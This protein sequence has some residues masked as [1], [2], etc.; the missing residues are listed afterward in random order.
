MKRKEREDEVDDNIIT[1]DEEEEYTEEELKTI[2][3]KDIC[4]HRSTNK[5]QHLT[6]NN[7][8]DNNNNDI[9]LKY[10][11]HRY[12]DDS[13]VGGVGGTVLPWFIIERILTLASYNA[14]I[15]TCVHND[16][17]RDVM[18]LL[19][20]KQYAL[21]TMNTKGLA[22]LQM[23]PIIEQS[24][25]RQDMCPIHQYNYD[26]GH[27][28]RPNLYL[29]NSNNNIIGR[30]LDD[31]GVH[32]EPTKDTYNHIQNKHC[33]IK[34]PTTLYLVRPFHDSFHKPFYV[35]NEA[36]K[37][38]RKVHIQGAVP[39][40]QQPLVKGI[41]TMLSDAMPKLRSIVQYERIDVALLR[42]IPNA[43]FTNLRSINFLNA[44][45]TEMAFNHIDKLLLQSN[46]QT[47][48]E[49]LPKLKHI[50]FVG[51]HWQ[52]PTAVLVPTSVDKLSFD[53]RP[54]NA[55]VLNNFPNVTIVRFKHIGYDPQSHYTVNGCYN[56][57]NFKQTNIK[58]IIIHSPFDILKGDVSRYK[59]IGYQF[60]DSTLI[61]NFKKFIFKKLENI[62]NNNNNIDNNNNNN[63]N[64]NNIDNI[65]HST[66]TTTNNL[67][68][69]NNNFEKRLPN[70]IMRNII[71]MVWNLRDRCTCIFEQSFMKRLEQPGLEFLKDKELIQ[72][73]YS[74]KNECAVHFSTT[75]RLFIPQH[76][77]IRESTRSK[78]Q[79]A[80]ISKDIFRFV[81]NHL[82]NNIILPNNNNNNY[83][84]QNIINNNN[85]LAH[86]NNLNCVF[87][88]I[89]SVVC[90]NANNN[91]FKFN[92]QDYQTIASIKYLKATEIPPLFPNLTKL[93]IRDC[94]IPY[95]ALIFPK[96]AEALKGKSITKLYFPSNCISAYSILSE[97]IKLSL[98]C[99]VTNLS[100]DVNLNE[101]P[102][103]VALVV[104]NISSTTIDQT[105]KLPPKI[106][107]ITTNQ[108]GII[109]INPTVPT[110]KILYNEMEYHQIQPMLNK[111]SSFSQISKV[112]IQ[113]KSYCDL[114][115]TPSESCFQLDGSLSKQIYSQ[116]DNNINK[117][118]QPPQQQQQ[119]QQQQQIPLPPT[120]KPT[121]KRNAKTKRQQP[122]QHQHLLPTIIQQQQPVQQ[123]HNNNN[124]NNSAFPN[125]PQQPSPIYSKNGSSKV[126]CRFVNLNFR[127]DSKVLNIP[128]PDQATLEMAKM[129]FYIKF[130][131]KNS[132]EYTESEYQHFKFYYNDQPIQSHSKFIYEFDLQDGHFIRAEWESKWKTVQ[133]QG[134]EM[135][136]LSMRIQ[137]D[138]LLEDIVK[139]Y[140]QG[141]PPP[142]EY[143]N[144]RVEYNGVRLDLTGDVGSSQIKKN[145]FLKI[146]SSSDIIHVHV[147]PSWNIGEKEIYALHKQ[148]TVLS[149]LVDS[150]LK[151]HQLHPRQINFTSASTGAV[152][153]PNKPSLD[154]G[155]EMDSVIH[156]NLILSRIDVTYQP[157][158]VPYLLSTNTCFESLI[159]RFCERLNINRSTV[160]FVYDN[161]K[162]VPEETPEHIK[163]GPQANIQV[164]SNG[165]T[166]QQ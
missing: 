118:N 73:Y 28:S 103:L 24:L 49:D 76:H 109:R 72:Q 68:T 131:L 3:R 99:I 152:I 132:P 114:Y 35:D 106:K 160:Q 140:F 138:T 22:Q 85:Y 71:S 123:V 100:Q 5:Q 25:C 147:I 87:K 107:K 50:Y 26:M 84:N 149:K 2:Y 101:F 42:A 86:R 124:N 135:E 70:Y 96:L 23:Q 10:Y 79:L 120:P 110:L 127:W 136:I 66:T 46:R 102:N 146:V 122:Q 150:F 44:T 161:K 77:T 105:L 36:L 63:N 15:C 60:I 139:A 144:L 57:V 78:L 113:I 119:Q 12:L 92:E 108:E 59:E 164:T 142:Y 48:Q 134:F 95:D 89:R 52:N 18:E 29:R 51:G 90:Y 16:A 151:K 6:T 47:K 166:V 61:N 116:Q 37:R 21:N 32:L 121:Q 115:N 129:M 158:T 117:L 40:K 58:K 80:L 104:M 112:I 55:K 62:N 130:D 8:N 154:Q 133:V 94:S 43:P 34:N 27:R 53:T 4:Y 20:S 126:I 81:S 143:K 159:Q 54:G 39:T 137:D 13:S 14:N 19:E 31:D 165:T 41:L 91:G 163:M 97:D 7:N 145:S 17:L 74:I 83:N 125:Q 162:L 98:R 11:H 128:I 157:H 148:T 38:V 141:C 88:T 9:T 156:A 155:L 69:N 93:D 82:F 30:R 153:D 75:I 1:L 65:D 111:L 45:P 67:I 33:V 64:N 56:G